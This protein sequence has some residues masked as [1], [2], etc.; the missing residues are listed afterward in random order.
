MFSSG[1]AE[2][3]YHLTVSAGEHQWVGAA[4]VTHS[5]SQFD[6]SHFGVA[7]AAWLWELFFLTHGK[8]E[9]M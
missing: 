9:G 3:G 1:N 7:S 4:V 8:L 5:G 6:A 2:T